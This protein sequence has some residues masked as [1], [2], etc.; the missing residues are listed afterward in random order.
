MNGVQSAHP[1]H[2]THGSWLPADFGGTILGRAHVRIEVVKSIA[3]FPSAAG[4]E[5]H[6][7]I[8][9][10]ISSA[11]SAAQRYLGIDVGLEHGALGLGR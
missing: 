6:P 8:S 5:R 2:I 9:N 7:I 11:I 10:E 3:Q 1:V 4:R